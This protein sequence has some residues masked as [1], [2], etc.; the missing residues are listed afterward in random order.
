MVKDNTE[1]DILVIGGGVSGMLAAGSASIAGA[2]VLILE[3]M[4]QTGRKLLITG[5]GRCN[6][7]NEAPISEF[8]NVI[9]PNPKFLRP[10]FANFFNTDIIDL[11]N[12]NGLE[13]IS[14]RGGRVF[15]K[16]SLAKDVNTALINWLNSLGVTI[17]TA[18]KVEKIVTNSDSVTAVEGK[19]FEGEAFR[20]ECKAAIMCTGGNSYPATGSDGQGYKVAKDLGHTIQPIMPALVPLET[21]GPLASNLQGLS[22]KNV[23]AILWVNGKKQRQEFGEMLFTHFGLSGPII[24]S[25]SRFAVNE[26]RLKN[27]VEIT[28]DLKPALDENKL[29]QRLQRDL[30]ENGKK[31][32]VNLFSQWLPSKLINTFLEKTEI[33][34]KKE[35]HQVNQKERR[36]ILI[37][38]KELRFEISGSRSFAEA[39]VTS[40]GI[41]T[42]EINPK[43]LESK[44][45]K[46]LYFA[47]ELIDLDAQ[48]GGYN[49]QIAY[50]T[51]WLAGKS[52]AEQL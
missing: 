2:K 3:K 13:T 16:S 34:P 8:L 30:N 28:I 31:Q 39:I 52:A 45:I 23:N 6:I 51:G 14:E 10:A 29:D 19:T 25:L 46:G 35:C 41:S 27:K 38:M 37:L 44:L 42:D 1:F 33:D 36:K 40:G 5:K 18:H 15:P 7:T 26:L 22:L 11:L 24:L 48:T 32:I 49:L 12:N 9:Y 17:K 47:G 43:T 4:R 20:I 50:S 21:I